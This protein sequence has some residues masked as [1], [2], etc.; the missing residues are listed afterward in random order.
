VDLAELEH[1]PQGRL[2]DARTTAALRQEY[3][4]RIAQ[5]EA[6]ISALHLDAEQ[7]CHEDV[8][9]ARLHLPQVEKDRVMGAFHRGTLNQ[10]VYER[11]LA[12][13][14]KPFEPPAGL[15]AALPIPSSGVRTKR[16]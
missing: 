12:D 1:M 5:D 13:G 8:R 15:S 2:G 3:E 7:L 9:W 10:E 16:S 14:G 4:A 6:H 11:L